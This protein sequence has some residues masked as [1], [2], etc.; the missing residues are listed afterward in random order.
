MEKIEILCDYQENFESESNDGY[1]NDHQTKE[2]FIEIEKAIKLLGYPCEIF[3]G[4][5]ELLLAQN[6]KMN[7]KNRIF[8]NLSDGLSHQ[9]SRVQVPILCDILGVKYSGGNPFTVALTSNKFYTKLA[10]E[11]IGVPIAWSILVTANNLPEDKILNAIPYPVIVKPNCEGSSVGIDSLSICYNL[12]Q[13]NSKISDMLE[14]YSEIIIEKFI[15]G[16]DITN[17]IIGNTGNY[18]LNQTLVALHDNKV[19]ENEAVMSINDYIDLKNS[20]E[21]ALSYISNQTN[22]KILDYSQA[23]ASHLN[24]YDIARIDY[25]VTKSGQI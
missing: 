15:A 6:S 10:V 4:V 7:L 11:K 13:L 22:K 1:I 25:R 5:P 14:K 3:G 19:I 12:K 9:Y 18:P 20:Y 17:F 8:L 23:I 24:V 16:Y 21:N 2:T